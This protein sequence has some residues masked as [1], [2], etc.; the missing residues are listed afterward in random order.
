MK[1]TFL[2]KSGIVALII[3]AAVLTACIPGSP[4]WTPFIS[5]FLIGIWIGY[6]E[7]KLHAFGLGFLSGFI[8][9]AGANLYF[10]TV[11]NG[12]V[13]DKIGHLL[14]LP[15]AAVFAIAGIIGGLC[16]GLA[17]YSGK[18]LLRTKATKGVDLTFVD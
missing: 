10:D 7:W 6:K 1:T 2:T 15:T 14:G 8:L 9:W 3:I 13:L 5:T 18:L 11:S 16:S 17:L 4:W 12:L